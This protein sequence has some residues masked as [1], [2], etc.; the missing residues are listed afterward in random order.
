MSKEFDEAQRIW[1][2]LF[3]DLMERVRAVEI[4]LAE[5]KNE[6]KKDGQSDK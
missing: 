6:V 2:A 5:F 3:R 1:G 4:E